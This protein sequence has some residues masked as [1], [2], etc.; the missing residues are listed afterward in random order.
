M[1]RR[2]EI[3]NKPLF[4]ANRV[5]AYNK[6]DVQ[7]DLKHN[8]LEKRRKMQISKRS[9]A[10]SKIES[11]MKKYGVLAR[12]RRKSD[13]KTDSSEPSP[14]GSSRVE[15][16]DEDASSS[17]QQSVRSASIGSMASTT[18][19]SS[20]SD[21]FKLKGCDKETPSAVKTDAFASKNS[22]TAS[23]TESSTVCMG[24]VSDGVSPMI[25]NSS[26]YNQDPDTTESKKDL[27]ITKCTHAPTGQADLC[28]GCH[29]STSDNVGGLT[30][31]NV[32]NSSLAESVGKNRSL[33]DSSLSLTSHSLVSCE[34]D[35]SSD[36][37]V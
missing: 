26:L 22:A 11:D 28:S 9:A 13:P 23:F 3:S 2:H 21:S 7:R 19:C 24:R 36:S 8:L 15:N 29:S 30:H 17:G 37:S 6:Q 35:D 18:T 34:Y 10:L 33:S 31:V 20:E 5:G 27:R 1:K 12:H 14:V 32:S 16:S 4:E 25:Q